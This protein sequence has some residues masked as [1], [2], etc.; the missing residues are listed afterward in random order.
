LAPPATLNARTA[1]AAGVSRE[2]PAPAGAA[3]TASHAASPW[4]GLRSRFLDSRSDAEQVAIFD[5]TARAAQTLHRWAAR[6]PLIRRVRVWPLALSVAA[7][8]PFCSVEALISTA[9]LSLWVFTLDDLFDE[10]RVPRAEL[11]RRTERYRALAFNRDDPP[12]GDSLAAA[13]CEIRDDLATYPL[14]KPLGG[15]WAKALCG[16]IDGMMREY[17]WRSS[18]RREGAR[19]LPSYEDYILAG[20][21]SIGGPPHMWASLITTG[22]PS[23]SHH[24]E[25]LRSMEQMAS[26]CIRLANDLQSYR[27]EVEEGKIN[28][29]I[30]LSHALQASGLAAGAVHDLAERRVRADIGSGLQRLAELQAARRTRTGHPEAAIADI[31]RF[32][33]DFY[34][35]HDYHT[36]VVQ[37][38]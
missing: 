10:E 8:A 13:L 2:R 15:E 30:I 16:T 22:D 34:T 5:L 20:L 31:A 35:E 32:V 36:F 1:P 27:K 17:E 6:Y 12:A 7:A 26:T 25:H 11:L 19:S 24:R 21:Y 14:F 23:T 29:L 37:R 18:Y 38:N 9:R 3:H 28:A 33:C 4:A